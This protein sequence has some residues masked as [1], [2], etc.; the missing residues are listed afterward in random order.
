MSK[1]LV[2]DDDKSITELVK[3][4]LELQGHKVLECNDALSG[5]AMAQQELPDLIILDLMMPETDGFTWRAAH[6]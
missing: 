1:I 3:V 4:N 2:I 6:D 5:I